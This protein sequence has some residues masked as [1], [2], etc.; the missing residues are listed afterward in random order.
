LTNSASVKTL[1]CEVFLGAFAKIG[2]AIV[3]FVMSVRPS[4]RMEQVSSHW[5]DF[6]QT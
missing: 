5:T 3:S 1:L 6:E 4:T 2:E